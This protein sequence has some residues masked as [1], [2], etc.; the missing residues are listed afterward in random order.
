MLVQLGERRRSFAPLMVKKFLAHFWGVH[1]RTGIVGPLRAVRSASRTPSH[2][3][4]HLGISTVS[5]LYAGEHTRFE[6]SS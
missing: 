2:L 3:P 5:N 4:E 6:I 1:L